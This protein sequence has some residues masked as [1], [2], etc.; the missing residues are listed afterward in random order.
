MYSTSHKHGT[1]PTRTKATNL[2]SSQA[3][4]PN[5]DTPTVRQRIAEARRSGLLDLRS[6]NLTSIPPEACK[7]QN[8]T[9][10]LLGSNNIRT[11]PVDLHK[12]FPNLEALDLSS[13]RLS[14]I[15]PGL[16]ML[17]DLEILD[18]EGNPDLSENLPPAFG[19]LEDRVAIITGS[20]PP[21]A[22]SDDSRLPQEVQ[23]FFWR[24]EHL[25]TAGLDSIFRRRLAQ[26]DSNL[27]WF[28]TRRYGAP[29]QE[30]PKKSRGREASNQ[31]LD[32]EESD[33]ED[34]H[35]DDDDSDDS[36]DDSHVDQS[37]AARKE[38]KL[39]TEYAR[40]D[41]ERNVSGRVQAGRKTKAIR[42]HLHQPDD[43]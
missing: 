17:D 20:F 24:L 23:A 37:I 29:V 21:A 1:R 35:M 6:L 8:A 31:N 2:A 5:S 12:M 26:R 18:L 15:P 10:V 13:N 34:S 22:L 9:H 19:P 4:D 25:D 40:K 27:V 14:S 3:V 36:G 39:Q 33:N 11:I 30:A 16:A 38:M 32:V 43:Y 41:K 42:N 7:L 28:L